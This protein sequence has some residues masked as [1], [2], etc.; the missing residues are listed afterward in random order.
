MRSS[1]AD[2]DKP[3]HRHCSS[4]GR[5]R[6]FVHASVTVF[7]RA[8]PTH[9]FLEKTKK[10]NIQSLVLRRAHD[11]RFQTAIKRAYNQTLEHHDARSFESAKFV[12]T[13]P[14]A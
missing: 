3:T 6:F 4:T 12:P 11:H 8:R 9:E 1:I 13:Q 2:G 5:V 10:A 7:G 14:Q